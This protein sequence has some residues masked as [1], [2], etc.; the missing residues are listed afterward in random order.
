MLIK[1]FT[2]SFDF[3]FSVGVCFHN[4]GTVLIFGQ[5]FEKKLRSNLFWE[6][7]SQSLILFKLSKI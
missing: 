7:L 6:I 1:I 2:V 4:L 5:C 3:K